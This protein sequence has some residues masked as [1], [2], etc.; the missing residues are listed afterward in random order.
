MTTRLPLVIED[1]RI[2]PLVRDNGAV[3]D[4][5]VVAYV[6]VPIILSDEHALGSLCAIDTTPRVWT[7]DEIASLQDLAV[8]LVAQIELRQARRD[9]RDWQSVFRRIFDQTNAAVVLCAVDGRI[10][11]ASNRL[12]RLL[13]YDENELRDRLFTSFEATA[14]V[15][16]SLTAHSH[17]LSGT[18]H[19]VQRSK[20]LLCKDGRELR[21]DTTTSVI[22]DALGQARF[23]IATIELAEPSAEV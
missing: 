10:E 11:H 1:A 14:D 20:R 21:T 3:S 8:M 4:L 12:C 7:A 13:G 9:Q 15:V 17:L 5:G 6:G 19:E 2:H 22:R 16:P 18:H 23:T